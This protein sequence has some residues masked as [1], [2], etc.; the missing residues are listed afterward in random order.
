MN[1]VVNA[2][3][4]D[5][6]EMFNIPFVEVVAEAEESKYE[7]TEKGLDYVFD[8]FEHLANGNSIMSLDEPE[9]A[10]VALAVCW[11]TISHRVRDT[12]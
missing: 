1:I 8:I 5:R 10:V 12:K 2:H 9:G 6:R 3:P 11:S 7:I 4:I